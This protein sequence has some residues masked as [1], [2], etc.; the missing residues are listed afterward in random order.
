MGASTASMM[1]YASM[2]ALMPPLAF[3]TTRYAITHTLLRFGMRPQKLKTL[4]L[5]RKDAKTFPAWLMTN[6]PLITT[7][8]MEHAHDPE[9]S[10]TGQLL[11][12][13]LMT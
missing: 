6:V 1:T 7:A 3:S 10:A 13:H 9:T 8:L 4:Y 12:S 11:T 2:D 5:L